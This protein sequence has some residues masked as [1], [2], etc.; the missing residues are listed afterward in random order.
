MKKSILL[1]AILLTG[2]YHVK[3]Q[4]DDAVAKVDSLSEV[5][6]MAKK[7]LRSGRRS[8][9]SRIYFSNRGY[10]GKSHKHL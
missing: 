5:V 4:Q 7:V 1:S 8:I 2:A 3:A 6:V 9:S 10:W